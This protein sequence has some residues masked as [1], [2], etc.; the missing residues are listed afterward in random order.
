[1]PQKLSV[2]GH[3]TIAVWIVLAVA[4][5]AATSCADIDAGG[6][7][8]TPATTDVT[9]LIPRELSW[10]AYRGI[11]LPV[12]VQGPRVVDG[13]IAS[14][15]DRSPVG[16]A[17]AAIHAT[18]RVSVAAD[19]QWA[20]VGQRM[21]APGRGRDTWATARAQISITTPATDMVPRILGYLV[22]AYA[23]TEAQVQTYSTYPDRSI[24]RNTA[25]VIWAT[26]GWRLRLPDTVTESPVAAVD[27]VPNDMVALP[28][29]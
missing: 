4:V 9:Q 15:F 12:A 14:D 3:R 7:L 6:D 18:V 17:L 24:T 23:D 26:D 11:D 22:T 21:I 27:S 28:K 16:A 29:P 20:S 5:I 8:R 19:G 10:R 1:M 13:A 25:T 2:R